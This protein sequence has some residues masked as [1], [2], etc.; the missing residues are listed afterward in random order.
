[1]ADI[2]NDWLL[3]KILDHAKNLGENYSLTAEKYIVSVIDIITKEKDAED[4]DQ[5][6]INKVNSLLSAFTN[7][8]NDLDKVRDTFIQ[9]IDNS[10]GGFMDGLYMQ[11]TVFK[12]REIAKSNDDDYLSAD[13]LLGCIIKE[14]DAFIKSQ[15]TNEISCQLDQSA[16]DKRNDASEDNSNSILDFLDSGLQAAKS[17]DDSQKT[18]D[19]S[20]HTYAEIPEI[21][22]L[23]DLE[24]AEQTD[25]AADASKEQKSE[26]P[27]DKSI[28]KSASKSKNKSMEDYKPKSEDI[29]K[30]APMEIVALLSEKA[31]SMH[32]ELSKVIFG[33]DNAINIF[34]TGYFQALLRAQTDQKR[35]RPLATFLFAGPP[36]VGKTFLAEK[37]AEILDL[38]F[39]RFDMSEYS[40]NDASMEFSGTDPSYKS[41]K[42]GNVTGFVAKHKNCVLL[43]DEVEKAHITV[44]HL[45]LQMLDGGRVKDTFT[46]KTVSFTNAIIIFTTNAGKQLYEGSEISDFSCVPRKVILKALQKDVNP[47]NGLPYFPEAICSRFASGNV[48][49]FN[50]MTAHNLREISKREIIR[51]TKNLK[52]QLGIEIS[53]DPLVYTALLFSEGAAI[54]ARTITAR[55]ES[56]LDNELYELF[57]L[58]GSDKSDGEIKNL[59]SITINTE[60]PK[61]KPE[62]LKFFVNSDK[63]QV[64]VFSALSNFL[65]CKSKSEN[66][67]F[68]HAKD[69]DSGMLMLKEREIDCVLIDVNFGRAKKDIYLNVED[70][71]SPARDFFHYIREKFSDM[72]VYLL[73]TD[74]GKKL[75]KEEQVSFLSQGAR[76]FLDLLKDSDD[77]AEK[78]TEI[79]E[80]LHQQKCMIELAKANKLITFETAQQLHNQGREAEIILF[81]FKMAV[82][83]DAEDSQNI[84]SNVSK[85]DVKFDQVIGAEDAKKEL[86]YFVKYL[87]DPKKYLSTGV[88][89]PKGVLLYGPPGTGK[90]MLAKA[91]ACESD[92]TFISAEGNQF[93]KKYVGEGPE[94]VHEIFRTARKYAPS[95][96][97]VDEI[98][99][100]AK[101]R[102][103]GEHSVGTEATLTAFLTEMDGFKSDTSKPVFVLAATNF[104]VDP[105]KNK[106][107]DPALMRR[108]DRRVYID[109]P[110]R[111]ERI[112]YIK[113]KMSQNKV[114]ELNDEKISN[115]AIRSTG[116]S[117]AQLESVMELALRTAIRNE[118]MKV[119]D[120]VLDEA[121]ETFNSGEKK[122]WDSAALE[123]TARHEAGHA[124]LC[125]LSGETPSYITVVARGDYGG[126]M[127]HDDNEKK[128]I[129]TKDELLSRIRTSMGGR[130]AEIVYYGETDGITTGAS[131]DLANATHLAHQ[132][133]CNYGM[134]EKF[135]LSVIEPQTASTGEMAEKVH[136]AVNSILSQQ[137]EQAVKLISSN[138]KSID[139]MA[140]QLLAKNHLMGNEIKEIFEKN[141]A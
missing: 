98:D 10:S 30:L 27:Q 91:M 82:A 14:P 60:L 19:D 90:T 109:L 136:T 129:F 106:S 68:Y 131:S 45:F 55:S 35:S 28:P 48:I 100:I 134:D 32:D 127:Q 126:Y 138:K 88:S 141:K 112:S 36:G 67:D 3:D 38:P 79:C 62:I 9:H 87:K 124:L 17:Q 5:D 132:I 2:K 135:G 102:R 116:M 58:M 6:V 93:L 54:D 73:Q 118:N 89:A 43:F 123:R 40:L 72:P 81:E 13:V 117:L 86:Q 20:T 94:K 111:E 74:E 140:E 42:E 139:A 49:M 34:T 7:D 115:I 130:A 53:I 21:D 59:K 39:K 41:S 51:Q 52:E 64:L 12:A 119:T 33:Q 50:H 96:L 83:V 69:V 25:I 105:G 1:M 71:D 128:S 114:F 23:G 84:L 37:S 18:T 26:K 11:Q 120:E 80:R 76:E 99:A 63:Q 110:N 103:G 75:N 122:D 97:F 107:L 101:E 121:F 56:F 4:V 125:W 133:I 47:I 15:I 22:I 113:M 44:I 46:G 31:K 65:L 104:D 16:D 85:P 57:R 95:I 8:E 92:V 66:I 77:F 78:I 24:S 137:L 108:F 70:E 29:P 61:D